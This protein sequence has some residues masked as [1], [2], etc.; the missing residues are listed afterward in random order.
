[1]K[2]TLL[3]LAIYLGIQFLVSIPVGIVMA[4][5]RIATGGEVPMQ[6]GL[7]AGIMLLSDILVVWILIKKKYLANLKEDFSMPSVKIILPLVGLLLGVI[8]GFDWL[9]EY[10]SL[11]NLFEE[12]FEGL[13]RNVF[14]VLAICIAGP[15]MEEVLFRGAIMGHLLT[16]YKDPRKAIVI[17]AL[18]FGVIHGNPVQILF[19]FLIGLL[20]GVLYYRTKSLIPVIF[21]HVLNNSLSTCLTLLYPDADTFFDLMGKGVGA[22]VLVAAIILALF[23]WRLI[24]K[25]YPKPLAVEEVTEIEE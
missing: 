4:A 1:M 22:V 8:V 9:S 25:V 16:I 13:S 11:P 20:F 19:A 3:L 5:Q 23:C 21:A 17:S 12:Q 2:R 15:I 18:V 24:D 10:V 6:Y 7:I 14:G